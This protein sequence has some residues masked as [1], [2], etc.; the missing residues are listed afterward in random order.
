MTKKEL[1][2]IVKLVNDYVDQRIESI[3]DAGEENL[4][5][6]T[7]F[8]LN[9]MKGYTG[10]MFVEHTLIR[11]LLKW[12]EGNKEN[13]IEYVVSYD[14]LPAIGKEKTLYV[15]ISENGIYGWNG[16]EYVVLGGSGEYESEIQDKETIVP[17]SIGG[18]EAGTKLS[19][20][21]GKTFG[22]MFDYLLFPEINPTIQN[23]Y[24]SISFVSF[25]NNGIYKVGAA[26]PVKSN[27]STSFNRGLCSVVG[28]P[29]K[30]RAGELDLV[31]SFIYYGSIQQELPTEIP[32]GQTT[33]R[34]R[35]YHEQGDTLLTSK[36][37]VA[38]K[39]ANGSTITNPLPA[40]YVDSNSISIF[41]TYPYI[42]NGKTTTDAIDKDYPT[43]MVEAELPLQKWSDTKVN[44]KY[45]SEAATGI[46]AMFK[47]PATRT[48]VKVELKDDLSGDWSDVTSSFT[49]TTSAGT[50]NVE[51][52]EIAYNSITTNNVSLL[53]NCHYRFT[54]NT[55]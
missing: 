32:L 2:Y 38:T 12:I 8:E 11:R 49:Q 20:L 7:S 44:V 21:E 25:S 34:Y 36:G 48:I 35:A 28:Q 10:N 51:G 31:R 13:P 47:F 19:Q 29:S 37:N 40:G 6:P 50:V 16:S 1:E 46:R 55:I 18:I 52:N 14:K 41:G 27:F 33:Y 30:N 22:Q 39:D 17:E 3:I 23:P 53:G 24:A 45:A 4:L 5:E 43:E 15:I 54:L 9:Y 42:S 26:A